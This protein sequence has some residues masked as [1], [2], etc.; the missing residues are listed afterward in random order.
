MVRFTI[1]NDVEFKRLMNAAEPWYVLPSDRQIRGKLLPS[2][3]DAVKTKVA[4]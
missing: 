1:I 3:D 4:E 2:L